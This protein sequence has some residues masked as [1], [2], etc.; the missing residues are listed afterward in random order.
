MPGIFESLKRMA[1]GKPVFDPNDQNDGW[2][3]K[4][5]ERQEATP[6]D[7]PQSAQQKI[8]PTGVIKG[9]PNT[10]PVVYIKHSRTQL[11]GPNQLVYC[12][13]VNQS[14]G[15]IELD[16]IDLEGRTHD[17]N[18]TLHPGQEREFLAYNGLR[19]TTTA[20]KEARLN[21]KDETGDYFQSIHDVKYHYENDRT[22][23]VDELHLRLPI[24]DI[25]G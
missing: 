9:N 8:S 4:D 5:G 11:N 19:P 13:I 15:P 3:N 6:A 16:E 22:Y 2:V 21:Y 1:E 10:F 14:K 25:Y 23:S 24:R 12:A 7:Q 20:Y 18:E 17:L